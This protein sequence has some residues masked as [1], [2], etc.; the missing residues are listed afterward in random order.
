MKKKINQG[1]WMFNIVI[2]MYNKDIVA[3]YQGQ[4]EISMD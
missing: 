4:T 3:I 2:F 1:P